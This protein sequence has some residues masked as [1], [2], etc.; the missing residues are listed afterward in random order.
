MQSLKKGASRSNSQ[1]GSRNLNDEASSAAEEESDEESDDDAEVDNVDHQGIDA[2]LRYIKESEAQ[3]SSSLALAAGLKYSMISFALVYVIALIVF[4]ALPSP[5]PQLGFMQQMVSFSN[6]LGDVIAHARQLQLQQNPSMTANYPCSWDPKAANACPFAKNNNVSKDI[7]EADIAMNEFTVWMTNNYLSVRSPGDEIDKAYTVSHTYYDFLA[8]NPNKPDVKTAATW[9]ELSTTKLRSHL[10]SLAANTD[11]ANPDSRLAW[12]FIIYNREILF[13]DTQDIIHQI[14][15]KI[16]S[17]LSLELIVHLIFAI[18]LLVLGVVVY[19]FVIGPRLNTI[20]NNRML[21]LKLVL[22]VPRTVIWEFVYVM[23]RDNS[24]E[25]E[26]DEDQSQMDAKSR[27]GTSTVNANMLK[28]QTDEVT[29]IIPDKRNT[30]FL[31]FILGLFSLSLP[32]IVHCIWRLTDNQLMSVELSHYQD[33]TELYS[34]LYSFVW[35]NQE[36][37]TTECPDM[38]FCRDLPS[39]KKNLSHSFNDANDVYRAIQKSFAG[40]DEFTTLLYRLEAMDPVTGQN[41]CP[42]AKKNPETVNTRCND[43]YKGKDLPNDFSIRSTRGT[44]MY[45]THVLQGASVL[46]QTNSSKSLDIPEFW[47]T[48]ESLPI[49][50]TATLKEL[51]HVQEEIVIKHY[52]SSRT[53]A[54]ATYAVSL[55]YAVVLFLWVFGTIRNNLQNESKH[56][57]SSKYF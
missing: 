28:K 11:L 34:Q 54:T 37:W 1:S 16:R 57:R 27:V 49:E 48:W 51:G 45:A 47:F 5:S 7:Y 2:K 19:M 6:T 40:N 55:V 53:A 42:S 8:G 50:G 56:N 13:K 43:A 23:Y 3:D 39:A 17:M 14:P 18:V 31:I 46:S 21:I 30:T 29:E 35:R 41:F 4:N 25:E 15:N 12:N 22:L 33:T 26:N 10:K 32:A 38:T 36:I 20:H 52:G 9:G 24:D 44:G